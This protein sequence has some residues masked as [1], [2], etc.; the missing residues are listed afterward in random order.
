M[1]ISNS[2]VNPYRDFEAYNQNDQMKKKDLFDLDLEVKAQD[3]TQPDIHQAGPSRGTT[4]C[5][6]N[7]ESE[8]GTCTCQ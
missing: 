8:W 3:D 1:K 6:C 4:N 7:Y 5:G 2:L